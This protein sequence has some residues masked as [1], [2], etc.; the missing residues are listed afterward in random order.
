VAANAL[1]LIRQHAFEAYLSRTLAFVDAGAARSRT[2]SATS[3]AFNATVQPPSIKRWRARRIIGG[4]LCLDRGPR[5]RPVGR[6]A[7]PEPAPF[8]AANGFRRR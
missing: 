3:A 8:D 6:R 4:P 7:D 5:A 2:R 1:P